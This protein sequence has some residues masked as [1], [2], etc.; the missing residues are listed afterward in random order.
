M[1]KIEAGGFSGLSRREFMRLA[2]LGSG[3][4]F[5]GGCGELW[6]RQPVIAVDSWHKGVCRFC[7]TGC[8]TRIGMHNG[9]VV[10]VKIETIE[11]QDIQ[12][13]SAYIQSLNTTANQR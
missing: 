1:D 7:G 10:D 13:V 12:A 5:L 2:S 8:G 3:M 11:G 6:Q 4:L 9:R